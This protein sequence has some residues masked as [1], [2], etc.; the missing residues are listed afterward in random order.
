[1]LPIRC[2]LQQLKEVVEELSSP[3]SGFGE[4]TEEIASSGIGTSAY[5]PSASSDRL[6]NYDEDDEDTESSYSYECDESKGKNARVAAIAARPIAITVRQNDNG[7]NKAKVLTTGT[8]Q[9]G[10]SHPKADP[11]EAAESSATEEDEESIAQGEPDE[12]SA[13]E[14][15]ATETSDLDH[16]NRAMQLWEETFN[17][18]YLLITNHVAAHMSQLHEE[19][20]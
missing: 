18:Q 6:E 7:T 14:V 3:S 12:S 2:I 16:I 5:N 9:A 13:P 17:R 19:D 11:E 4:S 20:G 10:G 8:D 15:R 1:M